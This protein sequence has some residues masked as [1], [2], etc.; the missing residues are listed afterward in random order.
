[1]DYKE[2]NVDEKE[3]NMIKVN[4]KYLKHDLPKYLM[5]YDRKTWSAEIDKLKC[6]V[7]LDASPG[8]P[9]MLIGNTNK[10]VM[11]FLG[12][13]LNE[14]ILDRVEARFKYYDDVRAD[15]F[16]RI[17]LIQAGL[18]DPVRVF[19]K[20]EPHKRA[21]IAAGRNRLIMSVSIVD[22]MIEMLTSRHLHKLEIANWKTIPS[23]PGI[24]FTREMND[25]VYNSVMECDN[26]AFADISGWDWSCKPWLIFACCEGKID[27]CNDPSD[28]WIQL[29]RMEAMLEVQSIY[30]FSDGTLV[31]P[32]FR[33]VVNSGKF[34]TSRDNSWMR[35]YLATLIGAEDA[36]AAGD[37]TVESFVENAA[38][39]YAEYGWELK[40]YQKVVDGFE[41]CSRWYDDK[42][43]FP[44]NAN[45]MIMNLLH[46]KP[47]D[48]LEYEMLMLQF[49]DQMGDHPE[50][51]E[52]LE[53]IFSVGFCPES[54][55]DSKENQQQHV[56]SDEENKG[57]G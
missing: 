52:I 34:K 39:K 13:E 48:W 36:I 54:D 44:L 56:N 28:D 41:F 12:D 16:T 40:D 29:V 10:K 7:K 4:K 37:D 8:V 5:K 51:P 45:K 3:S 26:M 24:G 47:S 30:Q 42:G 17:D 38:D 50:F 23:K 27:L 9:Y 22:K 25:A 33:G 15:R 31:R 21:K 14:I 2:P 55:G 53:L 49:V 43:S 19:V 1:M 35:K 46:T 11:D 6:V 20:N 57:C 18:Y 32:N